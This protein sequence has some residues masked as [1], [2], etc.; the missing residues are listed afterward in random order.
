M[1][2]NEPSDYYYIDMNVSV[3]GS[4]GDLLASVV[5]GLVKC[6]DKSCELALNQIEFIVIVWTLL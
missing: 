5:S 1:L 2:R 3:C 4:V 6:L